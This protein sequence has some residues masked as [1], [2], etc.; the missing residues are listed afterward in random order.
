VHRSARSAARPEYRAPYGHRPGWHRY[1]SARIS[2]L[3]DELDPAFRPDPSWTARGMGAR[4]AVQDGID[5][6]P[7][8]SLPRSAGY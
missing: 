3:P 7:A 2:G 4:R 1:P 6:A 8:R 5:T